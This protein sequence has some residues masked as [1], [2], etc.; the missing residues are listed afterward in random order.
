M[1]QS[2]LLL[3]KSH[4]ARLKYHSS[5]KFVRASMPLQKET[6]LWVDSAKTHFFQL[7]RGHPEPKQENLIEKQSLNVVNTL[8]HTS[9]NSVVTDVYQQKHSHLTRPHVCAMHYC[10]QDK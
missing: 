2:A 7:K 5:Q 10:A 9:V 3:C 6:A 8:C 4:L 1:L